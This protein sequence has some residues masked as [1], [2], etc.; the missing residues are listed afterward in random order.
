MGKPSVNYKQVVNPA[1]KISGT[2]QGLQS[3]VRYIVSWADA[4][5]FANDALGLNDGS[6]WTWPASP[7]MR[8][9]EA[10]IDPVAVKNAPEADGSTPGTFYSKAYVDVT[11]ASVTRAIPSAGTVDQ[12]VA[13]QFDPANP[14]E[15]SSFRISY[16]CEMIK[17]PAGSIYWSGFK[18][19]GTVQV[20]DSGIEDPESGGLYLRSPTFNLDFTLHNNL[21][22]T[23]A[24][25]VN[26]IGK[27]NDVLTFGCSPE[28]LL[29]DGLATS[30][31]EMSSGLPVVDVTL[32]Y[33]WKKVGWNVAMSRK[34][35]LL[36]Y[37]KR[38]T[39]LLYERAKIG[40]LDIILPSQ[41]WKP[42]DL[43][44][45]PGR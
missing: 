35:K 36:R 10:R 18:A 3:T 16:G 2:L 28:T 25:I 45:R 37:E 27:V 17:V 23:S 26:K 14:V 11:F 41:R 42:Q 5:S 38:N 31:R 22:M 40:P 8:A 20:L 29:F 7:N 30:R 24:N 1:P 21:Q 39:D 19:D 4:F 13:D 15:M 34:G 6:P 9:V 33:K 43:N 12:P 32:N 44:G